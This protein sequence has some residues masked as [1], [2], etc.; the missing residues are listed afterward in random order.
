MPGSLRRKLD[1]LQKVRAGA[2]RRGSIGYRGAQHS[3]L[4]HTEGGAQPRLPA[5]D[6]AQGGR[7]APALGPKQHREAGL[8]ND[9]QTPSSR[10]SMVLRQRP[11]RSNNSLQ[12]TAKQR[13]P[14]A[15]PFRSAA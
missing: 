3:V 11:A 1:S 9:R 13:I 2:R 8:G 4:D 10:E 15:N 14:N 12:R 5:V 6:N 7:G